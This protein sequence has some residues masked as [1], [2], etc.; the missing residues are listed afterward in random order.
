MSEADTCN[1]SNW[2]RG[3]IRKPSCCNSSHFGSSPTQLIILKY[4]RLSLFG[5]SDADAD[6]VIRWQAHWVD[7]HDG[8]ANAV[9]SIA[10]RISCEGNV[11]YRL[12]LN[13][14][15]SGDFTP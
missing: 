6:L 3:E 1:T 9:N 12:L 8:T 14:K 2:Y 11:G 7:D 15:F 5:G 10:D 13:A 4:S